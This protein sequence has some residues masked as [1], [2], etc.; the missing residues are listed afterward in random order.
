MLISYTPNLVNTVT[1]DVKLHLDM[2]GNVIS[3]ATFFRIFKSGKL[4]WF[5]Q[6]AEPIHRFMVAKLPELQILNYQGM[7]LTPGDAQDLFTGSGKFI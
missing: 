4:D 3:R 1:I 6:R 2:L 7:L 5:V